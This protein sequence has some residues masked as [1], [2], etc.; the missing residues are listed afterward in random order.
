MNFSIYL[1]IRGNAET[2]I[3]QSP[4]YQF[5]QVESFDS[6]KMELSYQIGDT[7][8]FDT[9]DVIFMLWAETPGFEP[10]DTT[11]SEPFL[12]INSLDSV[13]LDPIRLDHYLKKLE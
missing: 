2:G 3:I 1:Q 11:F 5:I 7:I 8:P 13:N 4:L 10:L 6:G 12:N 9:L